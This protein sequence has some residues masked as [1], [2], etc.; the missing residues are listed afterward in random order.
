ML[1]DGLEMEN[2]F[3]YLLAIPKQCIKLNIEPVVLRLIVF[4]RNRPSVTSG[5]EK[6]RGKHRD[7]LGS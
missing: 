7:I 5:D 3:I 1:G 4:A 6:G 2:K